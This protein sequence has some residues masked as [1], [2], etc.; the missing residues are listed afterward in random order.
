MCGA[1]LIKICI[2]EHSPVEMGR[3]DEN[4]TGIKVIMNGENEK[5]RDVMDSANLVI[6]I[7]ERKILAEAY[8]LRI[9]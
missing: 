6:K 9:K 1:C 2:P 5:E 8:T 4:Y 3:D 7:W